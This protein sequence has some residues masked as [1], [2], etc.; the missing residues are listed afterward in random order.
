MSESIVTQYGFNG[1]DS[2]NT[3]ISVF[4]KGPIWFSAALDSQRR[5]YIAFDSPGVYICIVKCDGSQN[6]FAVMDN[7]TDDNS[8]II[9]KMTWAITY[10][11]DNEGVSAKQRCFGFLVTNARD[12]Y[13][14]LGGVKTKLGSGRYGY[15]GMDQWGGSISIWSANYVSGVWYPL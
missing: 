12:V 1:S 10:V 14:L 9:A 8:K 11:Q 4:N 6:Y 2:E 7:I 3:I 15:I 13:D 5:Q